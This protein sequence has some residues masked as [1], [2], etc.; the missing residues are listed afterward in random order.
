MPAPGRLRGRAGQERRRRWRRVTRR[1]PGRKPG[2]HGRAGGRGVAGGIVEVVPCCRSRASA[3]LFL[4]LVPAAAARRAAS[5]CPSSAV[6]WVASCAS[7]AKPAG[8][9]GREP[10]VTD[11]DVPAGRDRVGPVARAAM[12][13][14]LVVVYA[15]CVG[16]RA[17]DLAQPGADVR[18]RAAG[19]RPRTARGRNHPRGR[20]RLAAVPP[21][22]TAR[23]SSGRVPSRRATLR[24]PPGGRAGTPSARTGQIGLGGA[25]PVETSCRT[26]RSPARYRAARPVR[27]LTRCSGAAQA[28]SGSVTPG[29]CA[30]SV[31][32]APPRCRLPVIERAAISLRFSVR[33]A[34]DASSCHARSRSPR[35]GPVQLVRDLQYP[36]PALGVVQAQHLGEGPVHVSSEKGCLLVDPVQGVARYPPSSGTSTSCVPPA[37]RAFD[38]DGSRRQPVDPVVE[39]LQVGQVLGEQPF[40]DAGVDVRS[41]L[42]S[43][44]TTRDS[45]MTIR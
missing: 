44:V 40:D 17:G 39:V 8:S 29:S 42:P 32:Q 20:F 38:G 27:T 31:V 5:P 25:S 37:V 13:A 21:C 11:M 9:S 26:N 16:A 2:R 4:G 30:P 12:S 3:R 45:R 22:G 24:A 35:S 1:R 6:T 7:R 14:A 43:L 19:R 23:A 36:A 28:K 15:Q 33:P 41:A 34:P 18:G 10:A